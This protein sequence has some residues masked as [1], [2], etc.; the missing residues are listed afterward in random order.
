MKSIPILVSCVLALGATLSVTAGC[1]VTNA[2]RDWTLKGSV[3]TY[4]Q[5]LSVDQS[6]SP[7]PTADTVLTKLGMPMNVHDRDGIRRQIDYYAYSLNNDLNIAEFHFDEHEK[8]TKK[9]LW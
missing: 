5:Y 1:T 7:P 6:A 4:D 8:L 2:V 3:L 9:V